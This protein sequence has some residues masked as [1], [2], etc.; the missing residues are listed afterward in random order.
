MEKETPPMLT[1]QMIVE[2][3]DLVEKIK[4]AGMQPGERMSQ[5]EFLAWLAKV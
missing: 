4:Q 1:E 3:A 2:D 5:E